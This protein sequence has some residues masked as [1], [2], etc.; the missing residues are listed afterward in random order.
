MPGMALRV[1]PLPVLFNMGGRFG[2][3]RAASRND[4]AITSIWIEV[5]ADGTSS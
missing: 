5:S 1:H 2:C 3:E 4:P